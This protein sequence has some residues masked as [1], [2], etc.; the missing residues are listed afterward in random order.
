M[1]CFLPNINHMNTPSFSINDYSSLRYDV[2]AELARLEALKHNP[3]PSE[4]KQIIRDVYQHKREARSAAEQRF[5]NRYWNVLLPFFAEGHEVRPEY[6]R[7][8]LV[9]VEKSDSWEGNLFR[10]ATL[11]WSVPVSRGYGRRFRYLVM[12]ANNNKLM[13]LFALGDP[14][15]N[16]RARD[17]EIGWTKSEKLQKIYHVMDAYVLGAV[18]PYN[19]LLIG[20]FVALAATTSDVRKRFRERY[21]KT[22][23]VISQQDKKADLV[24][25]TT[26]SALGRS[27][28]FNRLR[29]SEGAYFQSIGF[30]LGYGHFHVSDALF[31][32][33]RNWLRENKDSYAD[34]HQYGEGPNWRMRTLGK[35]FRKLGIEANSLNHGIKRE[36]FIAPLAVNYREILTG[37][38]RR[39]IY[40]TVSATQTFQ[41]FRERWLLP[42][43]E[44]VDSWKEWSHA[45][46]LQKLNLDT[47]DVARGRK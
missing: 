30:T 46:L 16:M 40:Q 21:A 17:T 9:P 34:N 3:N 41:H 14:V 35:A 2:L 24:L 7:P 22:V 19:D 29:V 44:R 8:K 45:K 13:G 15:L 18:P 32:R 5:I 26:T 1:H 20:K 31:E 23:G 11:L 36:I 47:E 6:I 28:I 33:I 25:V 38:S 10:F 43:A 27:S 39:P 4:H 12:D 42:R 37:Q